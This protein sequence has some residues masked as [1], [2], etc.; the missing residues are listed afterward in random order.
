M[1]RHTLAHF[2][3]LNSLP[4]HIFTWIDIGVVSHTL[5]LSQIGVGWVRLSLLRKP[6][7]SA[8]RTALASWY[9][10]GVPI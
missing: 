6:V 3:S 10:A 4:P 5:P 9:Y 1:Y 8:V 7:K 2:V